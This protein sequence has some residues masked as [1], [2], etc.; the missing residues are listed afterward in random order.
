MP[1]DILVEISRH[2]DPPSLLSMSRANK[3][4]R[5]MFAH[6]SAAPIWAIVRAN[7]DLP[8]LEATDLSE[9]ALASLVY[10]RN[11][12]LCG[13]GRATIVDYA[14]RVR[15]C[16]VRRSSPLVSAHVEQH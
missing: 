9:M 6:R 1:L 2:L 3:M 10:E 7:V 15:W 13:R 16:K 11:C 12:H 8:A 5:G 14:L 4:M